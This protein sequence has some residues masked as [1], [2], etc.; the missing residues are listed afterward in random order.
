MIFAHLEEMRRQGLG[1][2]AGVLHEPERGPRRHGV[3]G[4]ARRAEDPGVLARKILIL[5]R[6]EVTGEA[7]ADEPA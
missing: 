1:V 2:I 3:V 6:G 7:G 4:V 5:D